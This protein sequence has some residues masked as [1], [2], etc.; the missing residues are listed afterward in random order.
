M[1]AIEAAKHGASATGDDSAFQALS[2]V[3]ASHG[4]GKVDASAINPMA[5]SAVVGA[6]NVA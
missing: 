1:A 3:S 6:R 5:Q 2:A 4:A